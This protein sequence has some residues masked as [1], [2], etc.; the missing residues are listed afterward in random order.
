MATAAPSATWHYPPELLELVVDAVARLNRGKEQ[1]LD[2]F[3]GAGV[4]EKYLQDLVA[5]V[6]ADKSGITK[7][8][9][10]RTVLTRL[11]EAGDV[12][13]GPRREILKRVVETESFEHCCP[14]DP[15][16]LRPHLR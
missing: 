10:A 1:E 15:R 7:F 3:R 2:F 4:P 5:R 6:A 11:N 16:R 14:R 13:L 9:I 8:E 12:M